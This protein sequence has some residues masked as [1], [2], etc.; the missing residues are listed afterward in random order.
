MHI[1]EPKNVLSIYCSIVSDSFA[2]HTLCRWGSKRF[3]NVQCFKLG[4]NLLTATSSLSESLNAYV[5]AA[6]T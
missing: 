5:A 6:T 2:D 4:F 1:N 3:A